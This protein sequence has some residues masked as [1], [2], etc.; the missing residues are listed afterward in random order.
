MIG[1][2]MD[3]V[4]AGGLVEGVMNMPLPYYQ[5]VKPFDYVPIN[6]K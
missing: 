3:I 2:M 5:G 1:N 4:G 6:S